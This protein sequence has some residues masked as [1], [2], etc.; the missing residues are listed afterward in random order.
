MLILLLSVSVGAVSA[1]ASLDGNNVDIGTI[2]SSE[3]LNNVFEKNVISD[4]INYGGVIQDS[5][6]SNAIYINVTGNDNNDGTLENPY[7]TLNKGISI[8]NSNNTIIKLGEGIFK[9]NGNREI[10]IDQNNNGVSSYYIVGSGVNKTTIDLSHKS[11]FTINEG[12]SVYI[13]NLTIKN[14]YA[15]DGAVFLVKGKIIVE[16]ANFEDN[17]AKSNGGVICG[18]LWSDITISN[19]T[20]SK[21]K[22]IRKGG[23][24]YGYNMNISNSIFKENEAYDVDGLGGAIYISSGGKASISD[25]KF[26]SN[27]AT[28]QG[29]SIYTVPGVNIVNNQFVN[30]KTTSFSSKSSGGAIFSAGLSYLKNNT[31]DNCKAYSGLGDGIAVNYG[32]SNIKIYVLNGETVNVTNTFIPLTALVTD[33]MGN[34]VHGAS[35][36]FK[37]SGVSSTFKTNSVNGIVSLTVH[38]LLNDGIYDVTAKV[39]NVQ[40]LVNGKLN[41]FIDKNPIDVYVSQNGDDINGDGTINNP[42]KTIAQGL[43]FGFSK[44]I[45]VN[46]HLGDGVF[47]GEGNVNITDDYIGVLNIIGSKSRTTIDGIDGNFFLNIKTS[48]NLTISNLI[49]KNFVYGKSVIS[50]ASGVFSQST[51]GGIDNCIFEDIVIGS[52]NLV[53]FRYGLLYLNNSI[54]KNISGAESNLGSGNLVYGA[55]KVNNCTFYNNKVGGLVDYYQSEASFTNSYAYNNVFFNYAVSGGNGLVFDNNRFISNTGTIISTT[56]D[57]IVNNSIIQNNGMYIKRN[58]QKSG[59]STIYTYFGSPIMTFSNSKFI[60][61]SH[62]YAGAIYARL[63]VLN[64]IN[65]TFT[66]NNGSFANDIYLDNSVSFNFDFVIKFVSITSKNSRPT[67]TAIIDDG[68]LGLTT[69]SGINFYLKSL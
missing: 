9:G 33:D 55:N 38:E 32:L 25:S 17:L 56:K 14:G 1:T 12:T 20:F 53:T 10:I 51:F 24:I 48:L 30:S 2:Q 44:H 67:L 57:I 42:F 63:G 7:A 41:V 35:V 65:T 66:Q 69:N 47:Y 18:Q 59:Y 40:S 37:I 43:I 13:S 28:M 26:I 23:A 34:L 60:N 15:T 45:N 21:N 62:D 29:G 6:E 50:I 49:F 54:F 64:C 68:K 61:C 52:Q 4:G 31:F 11:L 22:V 3:N 58:G 46:L 36:E 39:R 5:G 19:S 16:N 8:A 27:L